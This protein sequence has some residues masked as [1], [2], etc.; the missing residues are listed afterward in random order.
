MLPITPAPEEARLFIAEPK[1]FLGSG[2]TRNSEEA[3]TDTPRLPFD[4]DTSEILD[5]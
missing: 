3:F 4:D 2:A 5:I 1:L